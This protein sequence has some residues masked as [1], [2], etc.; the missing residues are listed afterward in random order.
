[1]SSQS[2]LY[3]YETSGLNIVKYIDIFVLEI[4]LWYYTYK[5]RRDRIRK[6]VEEAAKEEMS[7][8]FE[9]AHSRS[10]SFFH[11]LVGVFPSK[12]WLYYKMK[13]C[14]RMKNDVFIT[15]LTSNILYVFFFLVLNELINEFDN[16]KELYSHSGS[17]YLCTTNITAPTRRKGEAK[18][19]MMPYW[20]HEMCISIKIFISECEEK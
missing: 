7:F 13:V 20:R 10:I 11:S 17:L 15:F 1:M 12:N 19:K 3:I 18:K 16:V 4:N 8:F 9:G 14:I 2:T 5:I 6:I